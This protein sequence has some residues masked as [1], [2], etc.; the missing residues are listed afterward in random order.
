MTQAPPV[1]P[2]AVAARQALHIVEH[3]QRGRLDLAACYLDNVKH[4]PIGTAT[5]IVQMFA[6]I[7]ELL[8]S[9]D[10]KALS[11][12]CDTLRRIAAGEDN[13]A[14]QRRFFQRWPAA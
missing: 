12:W 4:D 10:P 14:E 1:A 13:P 11:G 6:L 2:A 7:A 5:T 3:L 9:A 8:P